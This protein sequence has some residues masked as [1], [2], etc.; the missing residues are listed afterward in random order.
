MQRKVAHDRKEKNDDKQRK[1]AK[2]RERSETKR[3]GK[4]SRD[5]EI[6]NKRKETIKAMGGMERKLT[7]NGKE[8]MEGNDSNET[9]INRVLH[10]CRTRTEYK[11]QN[12]TT[13]FIYENENEMS[14]KLQTRST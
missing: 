4:E 9:K 6:K 14:W 8:R 3:K 1:A 7:E 5:Q 11:Q 13:I 10:A 12:K 2:T